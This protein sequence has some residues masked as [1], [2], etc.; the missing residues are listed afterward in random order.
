MT[1]VTA[2]RIYMLYTF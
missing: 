1:A 2:G